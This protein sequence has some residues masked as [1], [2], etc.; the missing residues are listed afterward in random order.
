MGKNRKRNEARQAGE[1]KPPAATTM[2]TK[3]K[4]KR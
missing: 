3:E 1:K 4:S 2:V